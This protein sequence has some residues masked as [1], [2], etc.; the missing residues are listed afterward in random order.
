MKVWF[1]AVFAYG[2]A[3]G[4]G[5]IGVLFDSFNHRAGVDLDALVRLNCRSSSA[6]TSS[7]SFGTM[8]GSNSKSMTW[9]AVRVEV[10]GE[11]ATNGGCADDG[12][13]R[14]L[15]SQFEGFARGDDRFAVDF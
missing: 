5:A 14:G 8:R 15:L 13:S 4:D 12:D 2:V 11:L 7:S 10:V 6:E 3:K 1:S 9:D